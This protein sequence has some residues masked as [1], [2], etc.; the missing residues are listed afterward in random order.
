MCMQRQLRDMDL[1]GSWIIRKLWGQ[2]YGLMYLLLP[3]TSM[4]ALLFVC[5]T[6]SEMF[7]RSGSDGLS[8][9]NQESSICLIDE[10][11]SFN[12]FWIIAGICACLAIAVITIMHKIRHRIVPKT[13]EQ[14][15][16]G[17]VGRY[18]AFVSYTRLGRPEDC[19]LAYR[20]ASCFPEVFLDR[21]MFQVPGV[22]LKTTC[23]WAAKM[24]KIGFIIA[25]K[26]Y[27]N[28]QICREEFRVLTGASNET[29][30]AASES[31]QPPPP[32]PP[33]TPPPPPPP[34]TTITA[35]TTTTATATAA[36]V[37][38]PECQMQTV[39]FCDHEIEG[40]LRFD[41]SKNSHL[42][43]P[44]LFDCPEVRHMRTWWRA[45]NGQP[46]DAHV[47]P[48]QIGQPNDAHVQP[49]QIGQPRD[50]RD[51]NVQ[52]KIIFLSSMIDNKTVRNALWFDTPRMLLHVLT[53]ETRALQN[54]FRVHSPYLF[55]NWE[56]TA[57]KICERNSTFW[58]KALF[59]KLLCSVL[60]TWIL[61]F[62]FAVCSKDHFNIAVDKWALPLLV[63]FYT[64][65]T[66]G[67]IIVVASMAR[68]TTGSLRSQPHLNDPACLFIILSK[69]G[70]LSRKVDVYIDTTFELQP[71][72]RDAEFKRKAEKNVGLL[73]KLVEM[74]SDSR[75]E[76]QFASLAHVAELNVPLENSRHLL[77][78]VHEKSSSRLSSNLVQSDNVTLVIWGSRVSGRDS[79]GA[80]YERF[81]RRWMH[82]SKTPLNFKRICTV[83][84]LCAIQHQSL[85]I[86]GGSMTGLNWSSFNTDLRKHLSQSR[87]FFRRLRTRIS[88]W[89]R[90][91]I[92]NEED[93]D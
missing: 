44:T 58:R 38:Q 36:A 29:P 62:P 56:G 18:P 51:L 3:G 71:D 27:V 37:L 13:M 49:T 75:S 60:L 48:T 21:D 31:A 67:I 45:Q 89:L 53:A 24:S 64:A 66:I 2:S 28:S 14:L 88:V 40:C 83:L 7:L 85:D 76:A 82:L 92:M 50:A 41:S 23:L 5:V 35:A 43:D 26:G 16:E 81:Q 74:T 90:M 8:G 77:A 22:I 54:M 39:I 32:P 86:D 12:V 87:G 20:I 9:T 84:L 30:L 34:S 80:L 42:N 46:R 63:S 68:H 33:P 59:W 61:P 93:D 79:S 52:P 78:F 55:E 73:K 69:L 25:S 6:R 70:L 17:L 57:M 15:F 4:V 72:G 1:H 19:E 10:T 47:Q 65:F 91:M 11:T